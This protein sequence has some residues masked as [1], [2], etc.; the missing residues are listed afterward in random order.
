MTEYIGNTPVSVFEEISIQ[1]GS[2]FDEIDLID[3]NKNIVL[4]GDEEGYNI[5]IDFSLIEDIHPENESI[6]SQRS[7][8]KELA[9]QE[10]SNNFIRTDKLDGW[11]SIESI[12]FPEDSELRNLRNGVISGIYLPYPKH[13]SQ[14]NR[15][16][17]K[18]VTGFIQLD[19]G[20]DGTIALVTR[21]ELGGSLLFSLQSQSNYGRLVSLRPKS[22]VKGS[23]GR[24][25]GRVFGGGSTRDDTI[26]GSFGR[27][28]GRS[29]STESEKNRALMY[30][31]NLDG[32]LI[33]DKVIEGN[34][35]F[36]VSFNIEKS[37][38]AGR[39]FGRSFGGG[40]EFNE[41]PEIE[42]RTNTSFGRDFGRNFGGN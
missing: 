17:Q 19:I 5:D 11:L 10:A 7:N 29:F 30:S 6:E 8:V 16:N 21:F 38:S 27:N 25:F 20:L 22:I 13:F 2:E 34:I 36:S 15:G 31:L 37:G 24:N 18:R 26:D 4:I 14:E 28:F 9:S 1:S 42:I 35:N 12:S 23:H 32:S 40:G 3:K 33:L 41:R 39:S